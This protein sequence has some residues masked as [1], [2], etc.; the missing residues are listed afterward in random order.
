MKTRAG[1]VTQGG[2]KHQRADFQ[3]ERINYPVVGVVLDTFCSDDTL[4]TLAGVYQDGRASSCQARVM[5]IQDGSNQ[6]W[7]LP[8]VTILSNSGTGED[9]FSEEIPKGTTGTINGSELRAD[10]RDMSPIQLNGDWCIVQFI[11]GSIHQPVMMNWFPHPANRKDALTENTTRGNLPQARRQAKRFQGLRWVIT[12][13]GTLLIDTSESNHKLTE[14]RTTREANAEGGDVRFTVKRGREYEVNFNPFV[15]QQDANGN[16]VDPDFLYP[17]GARPETR[18]ETSTR[19]LMDQDFIRAVAGRVH[20][21]SA[22]ENLYFGTE[23]SASENFVLGQELKSLLT[24]ILNALLTHTHPTALGPS[25]P[26]LEPSLSE[27]TQALNSV[28]A[29]EQLS[30]WIFG[31]KDPP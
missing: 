18:E 23:S 15:L 29:D 4:N 28:L 19:L 10:F 7:I 22:S 16:L 31:Q 21:I 13:D 6:P 25:G 17:P 20:E 3:H 12:S 1:T 11:G 14:D 5:V 30:N 26:M 2:L 8:N 27:L 9:D 24:D